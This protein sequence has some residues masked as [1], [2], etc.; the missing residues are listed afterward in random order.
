MNLYAVLG[1]SFIPA[2]L[3]FVLS[4][5]LNPNFR[6]R[7]GFLA[8]VLG[9]ITIFPASFI[10]FFLLR[11]DVFSGTSFASVMITA[12]VFNGLIEETIKMLLLCA[13]PQKKQTLGAFFCCVMIYGLVLGGFESVVYII[14]KFQEVT[15]FSGR[16]IITNLLIKR[17]FSAQA[18]HAFCAALSGLYLWNFRHFKSKNILPFVFAVLLHGIYNFF[19]GFT[20][21]FRWLAFVSII[22]AAVECRIFYLSA[23]SSKVSSEIS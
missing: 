4:K 22:F 2:I 11:L 13:L 8:C 1:I 16:E 9:L 17:I 5:V 21:G 10:Q 15:L 20:S 23:K 6:A 19:I 3:F 18:I 14:R 12:I 7:Y